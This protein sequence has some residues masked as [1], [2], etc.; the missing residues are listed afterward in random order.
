MHLSF[1]TLPLRLQSALK[2]TGE[3]HYD[4]LALGRNLLLSEWCETQQDFL[5]I[6]QLL[7]TR[8]WPNACTKNAS[9]AY[10]FSNVLQSELLLGL[11]F[12]S[13]EMIL[14]IV[15]SIASSQGS[16]R[17]RKVHTRG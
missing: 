9:H 15:A 8:S 4:W 11:L 2:D 12:T 10:S 7:P 14:T 6:D 16:K 13:D 5:G 17:K 3:S 1:P